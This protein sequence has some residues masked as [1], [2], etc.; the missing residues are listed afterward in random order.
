MKTLLPPDPFI[1]TA[2]QDGRL[3]E[4]GT[5]CRPSLFALPVKLGGSELVFNT[6]TRQ[7]IDA[8]E[9]TELFVSP[10][11][12]AF[13]EE[14]EALNELI[15]ARFIVCADADEA[16]NLSSALR[17]LQLLGPKDRKKHSSFIILPTTACNARCFYC[18]ESGFE[19]RTMDDETV[20][21]LIRYILETKT[22]GMVNIRW[23]VR[24]VHFCLISRCLPRP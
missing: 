9:L 8:E 10:H 1:K 5:A 19:H 4:S 11:D 18:Y 15:K 2:V 6:F 7:L 16:S 22:E 17:V 13:D 20:D 3:P 24:S 12:I 21:A 23:I 14:S